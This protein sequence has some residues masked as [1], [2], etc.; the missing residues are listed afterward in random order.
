MEWLKLFVMLHLSAMTRALS[1]SATRRGGRASNG[2]YL[3]EPSNEILMRATRFLDPA[4][5]LEWAI[6][7]TP[8][9]HEMRA[10]P[11][12]AVQ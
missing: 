4:A 3:A 2:H 5:T 12:V 11:E 6:A 7:P 8:L 10:K 1:A 9:S